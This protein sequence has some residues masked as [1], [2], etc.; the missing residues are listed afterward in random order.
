MNRRERRVAA[1]E[2]KKARGSAGVQTAAALCEA[3]HLHMQAGR[4]RDAQL[5]CRQALA[6]DPHHAGALH[7]MGL[8]S[9]QAGQYDHAIT[10]TGRANEQDVRTD[11][12]RSLAITL[13]QRGLRH[14]A[15]KAFDRAVQL[16]PDDIESWVGRG[17]TL[18]NM[19]RPED[20]LSSYR[21]VLKLD[22]RHGDAAF[23]CGLLLIT[24]ERLED[25]IAVFSQC[26]ELHPNYATVLQHR[27]GAL[28]NLKRFEEALADN[29]RAAALNPTSPD[30]CNNIGASLQGLRRDEEAISWF[31]RALGMRPGFVT[32][33]MNKASSLSQ[34][35][36]IE[37][38]AAIYHHVKTLDPDNA[39][40]EWNISFLHLLTGDFEAGWAGREVRW[41]TQL[42]PAHYP[43]FSQ[44][45]WLGQDSVK[46]KTIVIHSDEGLGDTIQFARYIPMLAARGARVVL[47]VEE[48]LHPLLSGLPGVAECL[49]IPAQSL[50]AFDLHCAIGSLPMA[51]GTRLDTIPSPTSYLPA[52][53]QGRVQAWEQRLQER[54]ATGKKLR[55]GLVWS[56]NPKQTNDHNR[57][58]PL[59][60]FSRLLDTGAS[61]VSLQKNPRPA[62]QALL[63]QSDIIDLTADLTDFA[64]TAALV[65]CLDL[66]I[67][68]CTSVAHLAA[69]LGR[70]T[71]VLLPYF[72]DYR[73]LLDRDDSPWYLTV[74]LFRQTGTRDWGDVLDRVRSELARRIASL[75]QP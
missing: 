22:P 3:G 37:E 9:L 56:G 47:V 12:L 41:K 32:A 59:R 19:G 33:L 6:A 28:H 63:E 11:Y 67:T 44:P 74:R 8:L 18:A 46:G 43:H 61:F 45:R 23:R 69:A 16:K 26:N 1:R 14:Q 27:A 68:V 20:A 42:R 4:H 39:D 17:T 48:A 64:E 31:D 7:L 65:S 72:P 30:I 24:L 60:M 40:A 53:P 50:P 57:S 54:Q 62:D 75:G 35:R 55:V 10:W 34:M 5:C 36:R 13:E 25:A 58:I 70:P 51:F 66:V 49:T 2:N 29:R 73:W 71:W 15:L 52:A 38:A 21:E